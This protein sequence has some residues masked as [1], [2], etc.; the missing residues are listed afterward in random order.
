VVHYCVRRSRQKIMR[1][2]RLH[3]QFK[4]RR[5]KCELFIGS[6][7]E[8]ANKWVL[9]GVPGI[10]FSPLYTFNSASLRRICQTSILNAL[11]ML[12]VDSRCLAWR[13]GLGKYRSAGFYL[14]QQPMQ[15]FW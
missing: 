5:E 12:S 4:E 10:E 7:K 9:G 1:A 8:Y 13:R 3:K 6:V 15:Q 14:P 11:H 2:T